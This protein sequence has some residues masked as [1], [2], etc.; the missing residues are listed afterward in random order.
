MRVIISTRPDGGVDIT[1]LPV[2][3]DAAITKALA[4]YPFD[5]NSN[6][7]VVDEAVIPPRDKI[8]RKG[9]RQQGANVVFDIPV[10]RELGRN[11]LRLI[12]TP[13]LDALDIEYMMADENG[14]DPVEKVR[15]AAEKQVLRDVTADP[16]IDAA[17]T[18]EELKAVLLDVLRPE[19]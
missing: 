11:Q 12:R 17:R 1:H 18:L 2:D 15:I 14:D 6:A 9:L 13:L 7:Q 16:R 5:R 3:T 8:F 10:C 19:R 4:H